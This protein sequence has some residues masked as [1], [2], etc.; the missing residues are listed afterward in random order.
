[1]DNIF[2]VLDGSAY[3]DIYNVI[4]HY[5]NLGNEFSYCSTKI[6]IIN[7]LQK[8]CSDTQGNIK[9]IYEINDSNIGDEI[10]FNSL[11]ENEILYF[12]FENGNIVRSSEKLYYFYTNIENNYCEI[13]YNSYDRISL[14][15]PLFISFDNKEI[16]ELN[17]NSR[18][19][20]ISN[21]HNMYHSIYYY[22]DNNIEIDGTIMTYDK[23]KYNI[24]EY[25]GK[26]LN[27]ISEFLNYINCEYNYSTI[28][29]NQH[30]FKFDE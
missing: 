30:I 29:G 10:K 5:Y 21:Q 15:K 2:E 23:F 9:C 6:E 27:S 24:F 13:G 3:A 12:Y 17:F 4:N 25:N 28:F 26:K 16:C 8:Y 22:D 14:H 19:S 11:D 7:M 20:H 1:M 18:Q